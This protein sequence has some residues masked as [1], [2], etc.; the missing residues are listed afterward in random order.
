MYKDNNLTH[1]WCSLLHSG[2]FSMQFNCS[3]YCTAQNAFVRNFT[4][5]LTNTVV[6]VFLLIAS[7]NL[8]YFMISFLKKTRNGAPVFISCLASNYYQVFFLNQSRPPLLQQF[9]NM[10][11]QFLVHRTCLPFSATAR[12][13]LKITCSIHLTVNLHCYCYWIWK[14]YDFSNQMKP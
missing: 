2:I 13:Y 4:T 7:H 5:N 3:F 8:S 10:V 9:I 11:L 6:K 1:L 12:F 14:Y